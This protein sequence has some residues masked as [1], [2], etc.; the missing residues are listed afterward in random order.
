MGTR[1]TVCTHPNRPE[2][3]AALLSGASHRKV[4]L[5]HGVSRQGIDR[6][7]SGGHVSQ[8]LAQPSV[9]VEQ[10]RA[11]SVAGEAITVYERTLAL[12]TRAE[13]SDDRPSQLGAI[14]EAKGILGV[15]MTVGQRQAVERVAEQEGAVE[16]APDLEAEIR[17]WIAR[18]QGRAGG[19]ESPP[20]GNAHD[21]TDR[22]ALAAP[23]D[24]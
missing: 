7:V 18:T 8:L 11:E 16:P 23:R 2:L 17:A 1:C 24:G 14:R 3:E 5:A 4:A 10:I 22:R 9:A 21:S 12:L 19:D 13:A 15:L 20:G 6:H